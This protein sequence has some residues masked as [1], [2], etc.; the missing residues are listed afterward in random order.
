MMFGG[1]ELH[2]VG[3]NGTSTEVMGLILITDTAVVAGMGTTSPSLQTFCQKLK[4]QLFRQSY[5]DI[6]LDC[7]AI[8][9]LEVTFT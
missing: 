3:I 1:R 7:F 5:P 9:V 6:V 4:T 2:R 8:V